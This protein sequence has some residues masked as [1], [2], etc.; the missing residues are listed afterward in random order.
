MKPLSKD[1]FFADYAKPSN[2]DV[3]TS[4]DILIMPAFRYRNSFSEDQDIFKELR[5]DYDRTLLFY[6]DNQ[7]SLPV[8][9]E[10]ILRPADYVL[11]F[12]VVVSTIE[13]LLTIYQFL[14]DKLPNKKFQLKQAIKIEDYYYELEEFE[15]TTEQYKTVMEERIWLLETLNKK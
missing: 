2:F 12:G 15:G 3:L 1:Q 6:C 5:S 14:K 10:E 4:A 13:G 8:L 11:F 7:E 9:L